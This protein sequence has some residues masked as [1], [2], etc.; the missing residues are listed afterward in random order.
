MRSRWSVKEST[1]GRHDSTVD[2]AT[3]TTTA[4]RVKGRLNN[5]VTAAEL[6][7]DDVTNGGGDGAWGEGILSTL[8]NLDS[9]GSGNGARDKSEERESV[10]HFER[11]YKERMRKNE[12]IFI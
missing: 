9:E 3:L 5:I 6:E 2:I 7:S 11:L 1:Y 8:T 10:D 4:R 12:L